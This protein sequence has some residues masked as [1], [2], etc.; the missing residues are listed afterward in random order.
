M[1]RLLV[2]VLALAT[3]GAIVTPLAL[4]KL[5]KGQVTAG[6]YKTAV[7][8]GTE[9]MKGYM[10]R[11]HLFKPEKKATKVDGKHSFHLQTFAFLK[12]LKED[13]VPADGV[14][15]FCGVGG[16]TPISP[17]GLHGVPAGL[18]DIKGP[19]PVYPADAK[20]GKP[21]YD[22]DGSNLPQ[23]IFSL[24]GRFDERHHRIRLT[25]TCDGVTRTLTWKLTS[26]F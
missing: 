22:G 11:F 8:P 23:A 14:V 2:T 3:V 12:W 21:L 26:R 5:K 19:G 20:S 6:V 18:I 13:R 15:H 10:F 4:A 25:G 1:R 7:V 16:L 9:A 24:H 17:P